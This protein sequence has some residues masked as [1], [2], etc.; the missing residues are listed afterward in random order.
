ME[1]PLISYEEYEFFLNSGRSYSGYV[2][3]KEGKIYEVE[4]TVKTMV[5]RKPVSPYKSYGDSYR[6]VFFDVIKHPEISLLNLGS[7]DV[8]YDMDGNFVSVIEAN[9]PVKGEIKIL[10]S[11]I[12]YTAPFSWSKEQK[13]EYEIINLKDVTLSA[14]AYSKIFT[15]ILSLE[16]K[17]KLET[18]RNKAVAV[19]LWRRIKGKEFPVLAYLDK[20]SDNDN[21]HAYFNTENRILAAV[22]NSSKENLAMYETIWNVMNMLGAHELMGHGG[23]DWLNNKYGAHHLAYLYQMGHHSWKNTTSEFKKEMEGN[24]NDYYN[25]YSMYENAY[26]KGKLSEKDDK[27]SFDI[28]RSEGLYPKWKISSNDSI[29]FNNRLSRDLQKRITNMKNPLE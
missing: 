25:T 23:N 20:K 19:E 28:L 22:I 5:Q 7:D 27:K 21:A 9:D 6:V 3:T 13:M 2:W 12:N 1:K 29:K 4:E 10:K 15:H 11:Q 18:V 8:L 16:M 24:L 26:G 17:D 14:E